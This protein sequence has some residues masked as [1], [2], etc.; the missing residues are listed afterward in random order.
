MH[1]NIRPSS[2]SAS[3]TT[4]AAAA[5]HGV[6]PVPTDP[7]TAARAPRVHSREATSTSAISGEVED[8]AGLSHQD[9]TALKALRDQLQQLR[10]PDS[11]N[12]ADIL[13]LF[14]SLKGAADVIERALWWEPNGP[15]LTRLSKAL[16]SFLWALSEALAQQDNRLRQ[17]LDAE[18]IRSL[19][20]GLSVCASPSAGI[21]CDGSR[22]RTVNSALQAITDTLLTRLK[23]LGMPEAASANGAVL[24]ILN[25]VSRGL[26]NDLLIESEPIRASFGRALELFAGW[27]GSDQS[28]GFLSVH[29]LA[30]CAVQIDLIVKRKLVTRDAQTEEGQAN[31]ALLTQCGLG[32]C[33]KNALER[34]GGGADGPDGVSLI[35]VCNAVKDLLQARLLRTDDAALLSG[36]ARLLGLIA[37]VSSWQMGEGNG[38]VLSNCGN[39]VRTLIELGVPAQPGFASALPVLEAVCRK[40]IGEVNDPGFKKKHAGGQAISNLISFVKVCEKRLQL[41]KGPARSTQSNG[42]NALSRDALIQAASVLCA[43]LWTEDAQ[44][45]SKPESIGG[46]LSGLCYLWH[47]GLVALAAADRDWIAALLGSLARIQSKRWDDTSRAV[48]LPALEALMDRGLTTL[49]AAQPALARLLDVAPAST[50]GYTRQDL[51]Q[52]IQR[53]GVVQEEMEALPPPAQ[54]SASAPVPTPATA[55]AAAAPSREIPGLTR[56]VMPTTTASILPIAHSSAAPAKLA[57]RVPAGPVSDAWQTPSKVARGDNSHPTLPVAA[58]APQ[59]QVRA[60]APKPS[61]ALPSQAQTAAAAPLS[62]STQSKV[63]QTAAGKG[64]PAAPQ[65]K[66]NGDGKVKAKG[67]PQTPAQQWFA[68]LKGQD[69]DCLTRLKKLAQSQPSLLNGTDGGGR[70]ALFHAIARGKADVVTWLAT[71][72]KYVQ[73]APVPALVDALLDEVVLYNPAFGAAL[74]VFLTR[75]SKAAKEEL[76]CHFAR[77]APDMVDVAPILIECGLML[78]SEVKGREDI[79][80]ESSVS[81]S[82]SVEDRVAR[83]RAV[84]EQGGAAFQYRFGQMLVQGIGVTKDLSEAAKWFRKAGVQ[85][86]VEAQYTLGTMLQHGAGVSQDLSGAVTCYRRAARQGFAMAQHNL[87]L[88]LHLGIGLTKDLSKA[89]EWHRKAARQGEPLSQYSLAFLLEQGEGVPQDLGEA[90]DWYRKAAEQGNVE[91]RARLDQLQVKDGP[92]ATNE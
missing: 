34:L 27:L 88:M 52:A 91:A 1:S 19:C 87:G 28:R 11:S 14:V 82:E 70:G 44:A 6:T 66:V 51:A 13:T 80:A 63:Q 47:R 33:S 67:K 39:F 36:L 79:G 45:F 30:K 41:Q 77:R 35:N 42:A 83:C 43:K 60:S 92:S 89:V 8:A 48:V 17:S 55:S 3:N 56:L 90:V 68:L 75:Q 9:K 58:T 15:E 31:R 29:Q 71:H 37:Q 21:I 46:L 53:L 26:K 40:V 16:V 64:K 20:H 5:Q 25:W 38:Q 24:D 73:R 54:P 12:L 61:A 69:K 85:G 50:A 7:G 72:D 32:L 2:S 62:T 18:A 23:Q 10:T 49:D 84:A 4:N 81:T 76:K 74:K 59:V 65:G 57:S 22:K 86:H 78:R